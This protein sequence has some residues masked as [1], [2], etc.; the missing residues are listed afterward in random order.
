MKKYKAIIFDMDGTLFDTEKISLEAWFKAG[1]KFNL[2]LCSE[3]IVNLLLG[4]LALDEN[5]NEYLAKF[6]KGNYNPFLLFEKEIGQRAEQHPMAKWK[7]MNLKKK[8]QS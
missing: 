7:E 6:S 2:P 3:Q 1:E 5:E 4:L 8:S